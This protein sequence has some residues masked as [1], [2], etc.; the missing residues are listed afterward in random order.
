LEFPVLEENWCALEE[1]YLFEGIEK[2]SWFD[3]DMDL[4]I[5]M[6]FQTISKIRQR[7]MLKNTILNFI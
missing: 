4:E 3:S 6:R 5:G 1:I 7:K 2:Y